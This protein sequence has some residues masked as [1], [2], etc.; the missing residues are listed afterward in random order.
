VRL[1][2][3][4]RIEFSANHTYFR[5]VP[6]F[7]PQLLGTGLL[8]KYLFQGFSGGVR[9]EVIKNIVVYTDLGRSSRTGDAKSSLNE[10]YGLTFL[11][12]PKTGI[13]ADVHYSR[14]ISSF[15]SG[16]YRA[17]S[18]SRNLGEGFH[19]EVLGGNQTFTSS[20]AGNQN[21]KFLTTNMD[22]TLGALFFLQGGFTVYRGQLQNYNQWNLTLGYRFDNK[23]TRK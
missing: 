6:T 16:A 12:V 5:D 3:L 22:T 11:R 2:P 14:F 15:G 19:M 23:W 9:I 1:Q 10:M 17:F 8:D 4:S 20:L 7:D 21:A 18:I 13:R